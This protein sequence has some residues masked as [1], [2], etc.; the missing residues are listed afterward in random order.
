MNIYCYELD[1]NPTYEG[2]S[3]RGYQWE[4]GLY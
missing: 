4:L 3:M 1:D 2:G